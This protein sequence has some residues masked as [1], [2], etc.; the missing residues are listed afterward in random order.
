MHLS[1]IGPDKA[2]GG[3]EADTNSLSKL[4]YFVC[5]ELPLDNAIFYQTVALNKALFI[6]LFCRNY[7]FTRILNPKKSLK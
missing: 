2:K 6:H 7:H 5:R 4:E 1:E 3:K